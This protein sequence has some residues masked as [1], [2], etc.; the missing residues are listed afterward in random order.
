[1]D[2]IFLALKHTALGIIC[3]AAFFVILIAVEQHRHNRRG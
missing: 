2:N 3:M 1:M